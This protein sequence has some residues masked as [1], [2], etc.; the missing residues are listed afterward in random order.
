[1]P[2]S[3][4]LK[5]A[6][7]ESGELEFNKQDIK[8][9]GVAPFM[10]WARQPGVKIQRI[11]I[12]ELTAHGPAN[13]ITWEQLNQITETDFRSVLSTTTSEDTIQKFPEPFQPFIRDHQDKLFLNKIS[14]ADINKFLKGKPPM[15]INDIK[16]KLPPKYHDIINIFLPK[17]ANELPPH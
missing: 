4:K 16:V 3:E 11:H 1:M 6:E 8:L 12:S 14:E 7:P 13:S 5:S 9:M 10:Y 17:E 15:D 2:K